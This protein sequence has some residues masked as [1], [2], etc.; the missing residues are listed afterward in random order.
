VRFLVEELRQAV[1]QQA[2]DLA[3]RRIDRVRAH[4][5]AGERRLE[6]RFA[7][8]RATLA[9]A[10]E[11]SRR[12]PHRPT[13]GGCWRRLERTL[14]ADL[15]EPS[16]RLAEARRRLA[17][18]RAA[19]RV[20]R[21]AGPPPDLPSVARRRAGESGKLRRR[22]PPPR[23]PS[24]PEHSNDWR[25]A[26]RCALKFPAHAA[27]RPRATAAARAPRQPIARRP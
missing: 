17:R 6:L 21:R 2:I 27:S 25:T 1:G 8:L 16:G 11:R 3:Q 12:V 20:P 22:I 14:R 23:S 19:P 7:R 26:R 15:R 9:R 18:A 4:A 5:L 13:G 24:L 10:T